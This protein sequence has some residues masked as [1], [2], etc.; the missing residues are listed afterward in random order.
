MDQGDRRHDQHRICFL[1]ITVV[2]RAVCVPSPLVPSRGTPAIRL[3]GKRDDGEAE[4]IWSRV[5]CGSGHWSAAVI[6]VPQGS[7]RGQVGMCT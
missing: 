3:R 7:L 6:E 4:G 1:S 5:P 2:A